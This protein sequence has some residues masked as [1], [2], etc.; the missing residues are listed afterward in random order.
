MELLG[1]PP[2]AVYEPFRK[3]PTAEYIEELSA[4]ISQS[5]RDHRWDDPVFEKHFAR[6]FEGY[7]EH[8]YIRHLCGKD[9]YLRAHKDFAAAHPDYRNETVSMTTELSDESE[10]STATVW[11]LLRVHG[12]PKDT[13]RESVTFFYWKRCKGKWLLHK[14]GGVRGIQMDIV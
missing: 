9:E 11:M 10:T 8:T 6:K 5:V 4:R 12:H 3:S 14:Q 13:V 1:F 7:I 2:L